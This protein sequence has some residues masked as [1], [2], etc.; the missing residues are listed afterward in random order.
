MDL[1]FRRLLLVALLLSTLAVSQEAKK[2]AMERITFKGTSRFSESQLLGY[3]GMKI[4][5]AYSQT[6]LQGFATK[7]NSSGVFTQ[8]TYRFAPTWAEFEVKDNPRLLPMR[9]E[10]IVWFSQAELD[11]E[12]KARLPLYTVGVPLEGELIKW[13]VPSRPSSSRRVSMR[14]CS[15][16]RSKKREVDWTR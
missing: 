2:F 7:L 1:R 9:L 13:R 16:C 5:A 8:V 4:G 11:R 14:R 12:L 6:D 3:L 10:N 15:R